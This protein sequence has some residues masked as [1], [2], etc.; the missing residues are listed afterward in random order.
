MTL[1]FIILFSFLFGSE[2]NHIQVMEKFKDNYNNNNYDLIFDNYNSDFQSFLPKEKSK[3]SLNTLKL[4]LGD[5]KSY[6]YK[7]QDDNN[8]HIFKTQ[9]NIMTMSVM[10]AIDNKEMISGL[11][12]QPYTEKSISKYQDLSNLPDNIKSIL[13][14]KLSNF[15]NNSQFSFATMKFYTISSSFNRIFRCSNILFDSIFDVF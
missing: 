2:D 13:I 8:F 3:N 12:I 1:I 15:P 11:S 9:F 7:G 14:D 4:S 6:E 10:I 5:I